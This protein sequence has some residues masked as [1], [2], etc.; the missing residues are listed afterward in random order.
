MVVHP[1]AEAVGEALTARLL[2][3][4]QEVQRQQRVPQVALTGGRVAT[5]AYRRLA[6][7]GAE[8]AVDWSRVDL[9]WGDER[10]VP[11]TD[12]D[13]NDHAT[14]QQLRSA[15][16][17]DEDRI[18]RMPASDG[19]LGLDA[20][21]AAYDDELGSTVFDICLLGL[22]PD[23]HVASIFPDHPSSSAGGRVIAVRDSPKPP[24]DRI[25]LTPATINASR[26]VWFLVAG[27][28]KANATELALT[29]AGPVQVPGARVSGV[30]RTVWL[31]DEGA[32]SQL[33]AGALQD[34]PG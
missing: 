12:D 26:E 20:A 11:A 15:L 29:G 9:W 17:L 4:L 34:E 10:F 14:L 25:S 23:G 21:A 8:S 7:V 3:R 19:K 27:A 1:D 24:P 33:P 16:P 28:D 6:R 22:G 32:A 5:A 13:R 30:Q 18:H 31:L 2:I